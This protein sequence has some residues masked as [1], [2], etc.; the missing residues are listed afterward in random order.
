MVWPLNIWPM[1]NIIFCIECKL[2]N[3]VFITIS[4]KKCKMNREISLLYLYFQQSCFF[5]PTTIDALQFL[6]I[7][8]LFFDRRNLTSLLNVLAKIDI[9]TNSVVINMCSEVSSDQDHGLSY[10]WLIILELTITG[11]IVYVIF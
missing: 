2:T 9:K 4:T 1:T 8:Y 5:T 3:I 6:I 11:K 7:N 10:Y